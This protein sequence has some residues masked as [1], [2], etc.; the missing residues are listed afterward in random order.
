MPR[1][2]LRGRWSN[3]PT[4]TLKLCSQ[5]LA[6]FFFFV[7]NVIFVLKNFY[8]RVFSRVRVFASPEPEPDLS[9]SDKMERSKNFNFFYLLHFN[10]LLWQLVIVA[11]SEELPKS[12]FFKHAFLFH[13]KHGLQISFF[14][15]I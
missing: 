9:R 14:Y 10:R 12:I 1:K 7:L 11:P 15:S 3:G 2:P 4:A 6:C 5:S 13:H 8:F